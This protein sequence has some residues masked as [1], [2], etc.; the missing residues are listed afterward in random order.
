MTSRQKLGSFPGDGMLGDPAALEARPAERGSAGE[1]TTGQ[2]SNGF[3][4]S[5]I[6]SS[7]V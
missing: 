7:Q 4:S 5:W 6:W 2:T 1:E 3:V